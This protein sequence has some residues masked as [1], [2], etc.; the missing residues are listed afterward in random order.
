LSFV[1]GV[2][3]GQVSDVTAIAVVGFSGASGSGKTAL[4]R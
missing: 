2:E 3:L 4:D 1:I